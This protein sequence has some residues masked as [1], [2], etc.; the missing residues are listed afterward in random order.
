M[1]DN[2]VGESLDKW[3]ELEPDRLMESL[4]SFWCVLCRGRKSKLSCDTTATSFCK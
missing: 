3:T 2:D 4:Y 1:V